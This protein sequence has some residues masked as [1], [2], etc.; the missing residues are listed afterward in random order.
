MSIY[1]RGGERWGKK[2]KF[3]KSSEIIEDTST[4]MNQAPT[5]GLTPAPSKIPTP[6]STLV[7]E[8]KEQEP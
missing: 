8:Q 3:K 2:W 4:S 5:P 6:V 7:K 1:W